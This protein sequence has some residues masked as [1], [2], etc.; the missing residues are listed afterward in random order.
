[1]SAYNL[2]NVHY[3]FKIEKIFVALLLSLCLANLGSYSG[4]FGQGCMKTANRIPGERFPKINAVQN[5]ITCKNHCTP[6][7]AYV[8]F[9]VKVKKL[10]VIGCRPQN[11]IIP[12]G[13]IHQ[14]IPGYPVRRCNAT[15]KPTTT[16]VSAGWRE[17]KSNTLEAQM[18]DYVVFCTP[19]SK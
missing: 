5:N 6:V 16:K 19:R 15:Q 11:G 8:T 2:N 14:P 3:H 7:K 10:M 18:V 13:N 1:M 4:A 17:P 12:S 9:A